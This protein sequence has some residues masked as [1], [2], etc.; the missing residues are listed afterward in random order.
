[1]KLEEVL[2]IMYRKLND[3]SNIK[4]P[5]LLYSIMSDYCNKDFVLKDLCRK[6]FDLNIKIDFVNIILNNKT[7][8]ALD[9]LHDKYKEVN[10][11][12]T[13]DDYKACIKS[14]ILMVDNKYSF[15]LKNDKTDSEGEKEI[16]ITK[17]IAGNFNTINN[18]IADKDFD[19]QNKVL[20]NYLGN[21][22]VVKIPYGVKRLKYKCI[23]NNHKV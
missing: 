3:K 17:S 10:S 18:N 15:L 22:N 6:Y 16:T 12:I 23:C 21:S 5:F 4:D 13:L 14:T 11:L 7:E 1:M 19:I 20:V 2:I 8:T 9:I